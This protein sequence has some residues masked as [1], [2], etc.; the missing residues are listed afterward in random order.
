MKTDEEFWA[1][2]YFDDPNDTSSVNEVKDVPDTFKR[3]VGANARRIKA[4]KRKG[5]S[6]YFIKDNQEIVNNIL[7]PQKK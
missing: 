7:Y 3:W 2:G 5:T 4:A 1:H 6:P